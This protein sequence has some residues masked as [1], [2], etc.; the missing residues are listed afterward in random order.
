M[1]KTHYDNLQV[2]RT[3]SLEVIKGAYKHLSQKYHPD[4]NIENPSEAE[5]VLK[6]INRAYEVLSDPLLRK[7]HDEWIARQE[8][9][10]NNKTDGGKVPESKSSIEINDQDELN[11]KTHAS[12]ISLWNPSASAGWSIIF[13]PVLGAWLHSKN[14]RSLGEESKAN[15]SMNW[16]F[17][18]FFI[19][20]V[21]LFIPERAASA[22]GVAYL[23]AWYFSSGKEQADYVKDRLNNNYIRKSWMKPITIGT[24]V[25]FSFLALVA[26]IFSVV[27][28]ADPEIQMET[29]I[30]DINGE[31]KVDSSGALVTFQISKPEGKITIND[32]T[33][34]ARP[35][36]FDND[37][38][39]LTVYI[40]DEVGQPLIITI[41]QIFDDKGNFTLR[42]AT[43]AGDRFDLSFIRRL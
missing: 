16:V 24:L 19:P 13:S 1:I 22:A 39:I 2:T 26:V 3:A 37:N 17:V 14:W 11:K 5:R 12:N 34:R 6:I 36:K 43:E 41:R 38:K 4:K 29:A 10:N 35:D 20:I 7:E 32:S 31:W 9:D 40:D 8:K 28:A 15:Q 33:F 23:L 27:D 21:A 42:V 30:R 18:G 25:L